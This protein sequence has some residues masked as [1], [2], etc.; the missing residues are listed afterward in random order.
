MERLLENLAMEV[1]PFTMVG[2]ARGE[3]VRHEE[4]DWVTAHFVLSGSGMIRVGR[5]VARPLRRFSLAL[6]PERH[7]YT[8]DA[9]ADSEPEHPVAGIEG[10]P[11]EDL[12]ADPGLLVACGRLQATYG[13]DL[14]LFDLLDDAVV[15]DF[16]DTPLMLG[17]F[18]TMLAES[19]KDRPG[20]R[21]ILASAMNQCLVLVFRRLCDSDECNLP[22]LDALEDPGLAKVLEAVLA[23]P[24]FGWN[25]ELLAERASMSRTAFGE[26][27]A[28]QFGSTPMAWVRDVRLRDAAR[29]LRRTD[30]T[31]ETIGKRVGYSSR[32]HFTS[33]FKRY[34]GMTPA[35]FRSSDVHSSTTG[36]PHDRE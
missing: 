20:S 19:T 16:S 21:R 4:L 36:R 34:F 31:V 12:T 9:A 8:L 10:L 22:W 32:S 24:G 17:F 15:L 23:D 35:R 1:E 28:R 3:R 6:V 13:S 25:L 5:G 7:V 18:E 29:L 11:D 33:A 27:F 26:R 14:G 2:V 30:L